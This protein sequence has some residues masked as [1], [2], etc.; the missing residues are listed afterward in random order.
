MNATTPVHS[1]DILRICPTVLGDLNSIRGA[2]NAGLSSLKY[3]Q[4][5]REQSDSLT[6]YADATDLL[7]HLEILPGMDFVASRARD[8][9]HTLYRLSS[10]LD[11][12]RPSMI[13]SVRS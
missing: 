7:D 9:L 11:A 13:S 10:S 12:A 6:N 4:L 5:T 3:F 1:E 8:R 2:L